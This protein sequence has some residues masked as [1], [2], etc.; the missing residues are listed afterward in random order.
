M[1]RT[2]LC[3][4]LIVFPSCLFAQTHSHQQGTIIRMRMTDCLGPQHGFMAAMSGG[5]KVEA[6]AMCPEYVLVAD[7]VVYV[8]SGKSSDQLIPLAEVTRFRLLKNE[9]LIRIDDASKESHFH[10]KSMVLR[11]EWDRSQMIEEAEA[12]AMV[13]HHLDPAIMRA[14]Q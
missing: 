3:L 6:G 9:M 5:G 4:V 14:Q 13:S 1:K 11:P 7:K 8:I 10:I 2:L 12:S